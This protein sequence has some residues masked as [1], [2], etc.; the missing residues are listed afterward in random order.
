MEQRQRQ[1]QKPKLRRSR[2][3]WVVA[4]IVCV[5]GGS[6]LLGVATW[7]DYLA[8]KFPLLLHGLFCLAG[9]LLSLAR[10]RNVARFLLSLAGCMLCV[11][12][13][14]IAWAWVIE[15]ENRPLVPF[16]LGLVGGLT[17]FALGFALL[18]RWL[19][20]QEDSE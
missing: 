5:W 10:L 12:G 11:L 6:I 1:L 20:M 3:E 7:N 2:A 4:W 17:I 16:V 14:V 8:L 9:S 19:G 15:G 13:G 18:G